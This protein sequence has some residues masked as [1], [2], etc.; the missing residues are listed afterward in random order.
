MVCSLESAST[1]NRPAPSV[2]AADSKF[3][4]GTSGEDSSL[5]LHAFAIPAPRVRGGKPMCTPFPNMTGGKAEFL[6]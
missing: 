4:R 1:S 2:R 6:A 3:H 5:A